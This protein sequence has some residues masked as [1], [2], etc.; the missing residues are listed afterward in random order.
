MQEQLILLG[1]NIDHIATLRQ[2]RGTQYPEPI[3]AALI[4]EQAGADGI[5]AHL[6]EDRRHMQD[7]DMFLLKE[8]IHTRLN[9]EMAV[10]DEM[11]KIACEVKPFACCLVP[12]KREELTTEG[13]LDVAA[14]MDKM[15]HACTNL[16]EAGIEVSLFIDPEE[17]QIDAAIS[18]GAPVIELHTGSYA[19]A[20]NQ[21]QRKDELARIQEAAAYVHSAGLQVNAGHGLTLCNVEDI[22]KIP[23]MVELNIG[24]AIIAQAVFSGLETAVRD[25][26]QTMRNA[27]L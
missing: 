14:S 6:R 2:A 25:M 19:D 5:T 23:E 27:R 21:Q 20:L 10:T 9:F 11:L 3:Q 26:K 16:A 1:V 7:R 12:E 13:G 8:M 4:A 15:Q 22:C 17:K 18:A 24:H